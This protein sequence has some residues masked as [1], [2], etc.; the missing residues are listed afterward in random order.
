MSYGPLTENTLYLRGVQIGSGEDS[1]INTPAK[2]EAQDFADHVIEAELGQSF[3]LISSAYPPLIV[4]IALMLG[5]A[6]I[7]RTLYAIHLTQGGEGGEKSQADVLEDRA[8]GYLQR[9]KDGELTLFD[10]DGDEIEGFGPSSGPQA[11]QS[12]EESDE[13]LIF[14]IRAEPYQ[15][16]DP[17]DAYGE[18][19]YADE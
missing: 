9:I 18:T 6:Q 1:I 3:E 7:Y 11:V 14:D 19:E 8:R 16:K 17:A 13:D 2:T 12:I 4:D 15:Y 10:A 5:S